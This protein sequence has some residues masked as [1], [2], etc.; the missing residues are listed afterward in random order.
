VLDQ[1][2]IVSPRRIQTT[3]ITL[4]LFFIIAFLLLLL[5]QQFFREY[6]AL[7]DN[8]FCIFFLQN[9]EMAICLQTRPDSA[10]LKEMFSYTPAL[11]ESFLWVCIRCLFLDMDA[12]TDRIGHMN[13]SL[14]DLS[15]FTEIIQQ[16]VQLGQFTRVPDTRCCCHEM[17]TGR[18]QQLRSHRQSLSWLGIIHGLISTDQSAEC[19]SFPNILTGLRHACL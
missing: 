19:T 3:A 8:I 1:I 12:Q 9:N 6:Y 18:R 13:L 17:K 2:E 10:R 4:S 14:S 5:L 16:F 15:P 11:N 7:P